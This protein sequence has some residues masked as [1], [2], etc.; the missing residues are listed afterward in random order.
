MWE[1]GRGALG[2]EHVPGKLIE[3]I[4][5]WYIVIVLVDAVVVAAAAC[6]RFL[7]LSISVYLLR[8]Q[9]QE[10]QLTKQNKATRKKKAKD[11]AK[12]TQAGKGQGKLYQLEEGRKNNINSSRNYEL[13]LF[14]CLGHFSSSFLPSVASQPT[15]HTHT[16]THLHFSF[17]FPTLSAFVSLSPCRP[18]RKKQKALQK[19][20][21][22]WQTFKY[23]NVLSSSLSRKCYA[24]TPTLACSPPSLSVSFFTHPWPCRCST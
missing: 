4:V 5:L 19:S 6:L 22:S 15:W 12:T 24:A 14:S 16:H 7:C 3:V 8:K 1:R 13:Q 17:L 20:K 21:K 10:E 2:R 18:K 23:L 11:D 9:K